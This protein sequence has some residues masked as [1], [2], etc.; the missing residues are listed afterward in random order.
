MPTL[1]DAATLPARRTVASTPASLDSNAAAA[2]AACSANCTA[3]AAIAAAREAGV[4]SV[5]RSA[6]NA[7]NVGRS[8]A[9][10]DHARRARSANGPSGSS[11]PGSE[12]GRRPARMAMP[13]LARSCPVH[14]R[15]CVHTSQTSTPKANM[16][17]AGVKV[18]VPPKSSGAWYL[19][20]GRGRSVRKAVEGRGS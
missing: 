18:G 14:G 6:S 20:E 13:A 12:S 19:V 16:S 2:A 5:A 3:A 4:A 7:S 8:S 11:Q 17:H 9:L 10:W 15:C 1:A